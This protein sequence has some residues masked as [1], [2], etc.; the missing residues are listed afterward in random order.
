[1]IFRTKLN[2]PDNYCSQ[3]KYLSDVRYSVESKCSIIVFYDE[4]VDRWLVPES[5]ALD[6]LENI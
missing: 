4:E 5:T 2:F 6:I 3:S 1:M